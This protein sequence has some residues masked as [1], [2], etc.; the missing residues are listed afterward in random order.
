M[1][2]LNDRLFYLIKFGSEKNMA[3]LIN[4]G[5]L[6]FSLSKEFNGLVN[7][8]E[9]G[10]LYEGAESIENAQL[11]KIEVDHPTIGK[12]TFNPVQGKLAKLTQYNDCYLS[13]SLYAISTRT[14]IGRDVHNIDKEH[15]DFGDSAI[16]IKEPYKFLSSITDQLKKEKIE[17]EMNY[18][19]YLNYDQEGKISISPFNKKNEH[20]HQMEF[21]IIIKNVDNQAKLIHIGSIEKYCHLVSAESIIETVWSAKRKWEK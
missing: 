6:R 12:H 9:R 5:E 8:K 3:K 11:I 20:S 2:V 15:L 7:E 13:Y 10:D 16:F 19:E 4:D 21:R 17:Y 1:N 18:V 14:F